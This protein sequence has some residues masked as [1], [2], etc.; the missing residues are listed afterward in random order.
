MQAKQFLRTSPRTPTSAANLTWSFASFVSMTHR[1]DGHLP[2]SWVPT[3]RNAPVLPQTCTPSDGSFISTYAPATEAGAPNIT[4][5]C[6]TTVR[7]MVDAPLT[8]ARTSLLQATPPRSETGTCPNP[9]PSSA[10]IILQNARFGGQTSRW[11][12]RRALGGRDEV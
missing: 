12:L 2:A 4:I 11:N 5:P 6:L 9:T 3:G 1:R 8:T 10:A 7:F